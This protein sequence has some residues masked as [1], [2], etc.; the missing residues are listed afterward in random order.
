MVL[1]ENK[2]RTDL[3][4]AK[5]LDNTFDFYDRSARPEFQTA[6]ERLND[7]FSRYPAKNQHKLKAE[8]KEEKKFKSAFYELFIHELFSQQGFELEVDPVIPNLGT[9]DFLASKNNLSIYIE[10]TVSEEISD[11]KRRNENRK[12][13][14]FDSLN[15][16]KSPDFFIGI[17]ELEFK[18]KKQPNAKKIILFV[19]NNIKKNNAV[20]T[21]ERLS[22]NNYSRLV[23][24]FYI[25]EDIKI[26]F[27]L[28][29]KT[30]SARGNINHRP[31]A[32]GPGETFIGGSES[33]IKSSCIKKARKYKRIGYP[34]IICANVLS[35]RGVDDIDINNAIV[36]K[37]GLFE[38]LKRDE[39][40][41]TVGVL[42]SSVNNHNLHVAKYWFLQNP[43][44]LYKTDFDKFDLSYI[45]V[46]NN[47]M[48][49]IRKKGIGEILRIYE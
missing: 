22:K 13:V 49:T 31:I 4:Y 3:N 17:D 39:I 40:L 19:E 47:Q 9:P 2:V 23:N 34:L 33:V 30:E 14:L 45:N 44:S 26:S 27:K 35:F 12:H 7:W 6:R 32:H 42:I 36:N 48:G 38:Q 16:I 37:D 24:F 29:P 28:Y 1:F 21:E 8:F 41:N 20:E 11:E 43:Y 46:S 15:K 10:A 5:N 18:S 25:D